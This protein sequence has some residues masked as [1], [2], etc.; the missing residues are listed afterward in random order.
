MTPSKEPSREFD[1]S[2]SSDLIPGQFCRLVS[3]SLVLGTFSGFIEG[4]V[5]QAI[6]YL[7]TLVSDYSWMSFGMITRLWDKR[8]KGP[9]LISVLYCFQITSWSLP[10][11]Q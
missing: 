2:R 11:I 3:E 8:P 10:A 9:V 5:R 1:V 4:H 7:I 6:E